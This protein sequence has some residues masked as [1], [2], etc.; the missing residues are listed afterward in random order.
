VKLTFEGDERA[1]ESLGARG[2]RAWEVWGEDYYEGQVGM[3]QMWR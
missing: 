3:L 2:L 1:V